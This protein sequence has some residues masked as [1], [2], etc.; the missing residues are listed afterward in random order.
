V[1]SSGIER[2]VREYVEGGDERVL[3]IGSRPEQNNDRK[4]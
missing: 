3:L 4:Q 2:L 1:V